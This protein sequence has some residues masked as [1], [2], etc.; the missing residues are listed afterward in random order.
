MIKSEKNQ[1]IIYRKEKDISQKY[2]TDCMNIS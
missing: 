1:V 2:L